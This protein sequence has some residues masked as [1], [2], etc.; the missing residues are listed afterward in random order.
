MF[1]GIMMQLSN[2]K[3][4]NELI[5]EGN[6]SGGKWDRQFESARRYYSPEGVAPTIPTVCGGGHEPKV[7]YYEYE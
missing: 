5:L 4:T 6:L 7:G 1:G 2:I 3:S